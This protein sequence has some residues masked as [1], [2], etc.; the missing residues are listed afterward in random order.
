[1]L[2]VTDNG[3]GIPEEQQK[4]M[5]E[6]FFSTKG[7][8]GTGIGLPAAR[9]VVREHEGKILVQSEIGVGTTFTVLLPF[10]REE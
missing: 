5:W 2:E 7:T 9:K 10:Y 8:K 3:P 1:V 6:L 4:L